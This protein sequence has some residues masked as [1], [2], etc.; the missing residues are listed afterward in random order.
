MD[1]WERCLCRVD[2]CGGVAVWQ[3]AGCVRLCERLLTCSPSS[4]L[5]LHPFTL[6]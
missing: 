6:L 5:W 2:T 1:K 4:M 3:L